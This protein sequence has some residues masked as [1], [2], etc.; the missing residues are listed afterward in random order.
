MSAQPQQTIRSF[1]NS[2]ARRQFIQAKQMLRKEGE[3]KVQELKAKIPTPQEIQE[4][5]TSEL[6]DPRIQAKI[7]ATHAKLTGIVIPVEN[8]LLSVDGN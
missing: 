3:K 4:K 2:T 8:T 7:N 6:C 5:L 1:V